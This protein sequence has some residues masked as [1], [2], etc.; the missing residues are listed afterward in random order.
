MRIN[1]NVLGRAHFNGFR[2]SGRG[3]RVVVR[4]FV[5]LGSK[6]EQVSYKLSERLSKRRTSE[7][8]SSASSAARSREPSPSGVA[9]SL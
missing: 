7:S 8:E 1:C 2:W 4:L 5:D 9:A 6:K 3:K